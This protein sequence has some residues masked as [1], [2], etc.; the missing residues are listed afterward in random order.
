MYL[1]DLAAPNT[2]WDLYMP[3]KAMAHSSKYLILLQ[4][5]KGGRHYCYPQ[6]CACVCMR[7]WALLSTKYTSQNLKTN[8]L[9]LLV[10][11]EIHHLN[12][13][14]LLPMLNIKSLISYHRST[15]GSGPLLH[16]ACTSPIRYSALLNLAST[17]WYRQFIA[18][19]WEFVHQNQFSG[20]WDMKA[21]VW[22]QKPCM[23]EG[24]S[25]LYEYFDKTMQKW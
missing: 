21:L 15:W 8:F 20:C 6:L 13:T 4:A 18:T 3:C 1:P 5:H 7:L 22:W 25:C 24:Y 16:M 11:S 10:H 2:W 17:R 19:I 9:P 23:L 12:L 14:K